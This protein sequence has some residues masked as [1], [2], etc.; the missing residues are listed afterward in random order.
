[1][2]VRRNHVAVRAIV[3][4]LTALF[5]TLLLGAAPL[6]AAEAQFVEP[7][8]ARQM[9]GDTP[10]AM[11]RTPQRFV[12]SQRQSQLGPGD[13][14]VRLDAQDR[15]AIAQHGP[16]LLFVPNL[17]ENAELFVRRHDGS[18]DRR[19]L[20]SGT[21][22]RL[23]QIGA[24]V[25]IPLDGA[26][27]ASPILLRIDG[28]MNASG[29]LQNVEVVEQQA[30]HSKELGE[31][32]AYA[33]FGG[34]GLALLVY[35]FMLWLTMREKFQL[36]YCGS[37]LS[38]L[39]Y[40]GS[41]SGALD[42]VW[43]TIGATWR[44]RLN[45][46]ALGLL[47]ILAIRFIAVFLPP[48]ALPGWLKR[49]V[50]LSGLAIALA[51]LGVVV[52]TPQSVHFFDRLY[53][54]TF[55]PVPPLAIM[56]CLSGWRHDRDAVRVLVLAWSL[57]AAMALIRLLHA[58]NV[59]GYSTWVEHSVIAAM[60]CEALLSSL[61]LSLRIRGVARDRDRARAEEAAAR[62][63]ADID[64]LTGLHNR[65]ALL[66][67]AVAWG[68]TEPSRLLLIDIDHFKAIN[69]THGHDIGDEVLREVASR[70]AH[71]LE[72]R[73]TAARLGGEEFALLGSASEL[74]AELALAILNDMRTMD[75]AGG[76]CL[77]VSIG[78]AEGPITDEASWR[79]LYRNADAALYQA[80][81]EGRNRVVHFSAQ[82][83]PPAVKRRAAVPSAA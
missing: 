72:I 37:V 8:I 14:W 36:V 68:S 50:D 41:H 15:L 75:F 4:L 66:D 55:V 34:L 67:N 71:R 47:T 28:A 26:D 16:V 17:Q 27:P 23:T 25:E 54:A 24:Y 57:P 1:M 63:L 78:I 82:S 60:S 58:A 10:T 83:R 9:P 22:S 38:M 44:F 52:A 19:V 48:P 51:A 53:V 3:R 5:C 13:F 64:P 56:L 77:T 6:R 12:C 43:P 61:A 32:A 79:Q 35:N 11:L 33:A 7:C 42:L 70:L 65:R 74:P 45:Y 76:I 46:V 59:I 21:T 20:D 31:M 69:D 49:A 39:V 73:G 40:A 81:H 80:K 29:L 18:L 2:G 30:A 62:R